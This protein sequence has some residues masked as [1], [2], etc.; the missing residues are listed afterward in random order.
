MTPGIDMFVLHTPTY[1]HIWTYVYIHM[2]Y[3]IS[4]SAGRV[5]KALVYYQD[6]HR[7]YSKYDIGPTLVMIMTDMCDLYLASYQS[8]EKELHNFSLVQKMSAK[9]AEA[10]IAA[11]NGVPKAADKDGNTPK[12]LDTSVNEDAKGGYRHGEATCTY[13]SG[14]DDGGD[15]R[16]KV[17]RGSGS[18][19]GL[20]LDGG[21]GLGLDR[22]QRSASSDLVV[23]LLGGAMQALVECR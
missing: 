4:A 11:Q 22:W 5:E 21:V 18:G 13:P 23:S 20:G 10:M 6:A 12:A 1:I 17:E 19:L 3:S 8:C 14:D 2:F 16:G 15:D 7:Y 9:Q